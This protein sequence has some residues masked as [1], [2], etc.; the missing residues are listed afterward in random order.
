MSNINPQPDQEILN[1]IRTRLMQT[2]DWDRISRLLSA[3]LQESGWEDELKDLSKET[4]RT[5]EQP[6][7]Q[8]LIRDIR[9]K[10][11]QMLDPQI[12]AA[13]LQEIQ[14]ALEREV[15]KA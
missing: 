6:N 3:R 7:L 9:P 12:R 14:A 15:E 8:S 11:Q 5:Q 13:V 4:A 1:Q 2:G 10:A